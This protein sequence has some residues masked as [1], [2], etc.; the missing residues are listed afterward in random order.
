M[1]SSATIAA[2]MPTRPTWA[3]VDLT[4]VTEN[5]RE[6]LRRLG[7]GVKV[8]AS[9]KANAYGHGAV[10]V[11]RTL[12]AERVDWLATGSFEEAVA[13][14]EARIETPILLFA[15]ALPE[16]MPEVLRHGFVPTVHDLAS[17]HAV[18]A[19]ARRQTLV[20]IKVDAGL[21]RLGVPVEEARKASCTRSPHS[22]TS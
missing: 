18:S 15:G 14:R 19:A 3:E 6:L 9:I 17:A 16:A 20:W 2:M 1:R 21:G 5:Y 8:I 12:A 11:A 4:A 22:R 10:E 13:V 7:D